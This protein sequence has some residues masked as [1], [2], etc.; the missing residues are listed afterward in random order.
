MARAGPE[1]GLAA[2]L[3]V[4]QGKDEPEVRKRILDGNS[5]PRREI[6]SPLKVK[7][8]VSR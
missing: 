2:R 6:G 1:T 5:R 7:S 4:R 8:G 3:L